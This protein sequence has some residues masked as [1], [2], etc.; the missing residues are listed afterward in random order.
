MNV[1]RKNEVLMDIVSKLAKMQ[2]TA[3]ANNANSELVTQLSRLQS[4]IKENISHDDDL[5]S[6]THNFDAVY[7]DFTKRL[8]AVH[9]DLTQTELKVC[10]YLKMG[11]SSKDM[12]PL[13]NISYHSVEMT[14]Y[15]LRKKMNLT[16]DVNLTEY[17]Q[18]V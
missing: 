18:Q 6:F 2:R 11:L 9:P 5:R 4:M 13:F 14:R 7:E 12:A 1:V 3:E 16:R 10:C 17:L 15:R 8:I